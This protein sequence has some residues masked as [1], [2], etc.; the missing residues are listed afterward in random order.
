MREGGEVVIQSKRV[1]GHLLELIP[2]GKLESDVPALLVDDHVHWLNLSTR[3]IEFRPVDKMWEPSTE[4][5]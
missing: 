5:V 2:G 4:C 1:N 3:E